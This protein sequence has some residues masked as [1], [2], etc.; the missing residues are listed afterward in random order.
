MGA[1]GGELNFKFKSHTTTIAV[2]GFWGLDLATG[3]KIGF[4]RKWQ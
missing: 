2:A 3:F 1:G 4:Q